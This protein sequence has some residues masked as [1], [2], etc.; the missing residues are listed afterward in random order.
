MAVR[1]LQQK[2]RAK[3]IS[4]GEKQLEKP[5][6]GAAAAKGQSKGKGKLNMGD[7]AQWT[8][9]C[10][11]S[12]GEKCGMEHTE[13]RRESKGTGKFLGRYLQE[14]IP[15][16]KAA[17]KITVFQEKKTQPTCF[18]FTKG[19]SPKG[20]ACDCWRPLE[21]FFHQEGNC[22]LRDQCAFKHTEKCG[23]QPKIRTLLVT[24]AKTWISPKQRRKSPH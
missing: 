4:S 11:S 6:S 10:Q 20:N 5:A 15:W 2:K 17:R 8:I 18:A 12:R 1:Y 13:R 23:G 3:H 9:N 19:S 14:G 24:V 16:D 21:C 22:K 7:C